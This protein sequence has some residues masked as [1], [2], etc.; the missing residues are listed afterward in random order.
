VDNE[1]SRQRLQ[2]IFEMRTELEKLGPK[3]QQTIDQP[4]KLPEPTANSEC[5]IAKLPG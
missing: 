2:R 1:E 4:A 3:P 5:N